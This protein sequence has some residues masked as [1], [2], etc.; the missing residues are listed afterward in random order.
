[1]NTITSNVNSG[2]VSKKGRDNLRT[3]KE[4]HLDMESHH[5]EMIKEKPSKAAVECFKRK[6]YS[7]RGDTNGQR[8]STGIQN[9]ERR[10]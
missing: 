4:R 2:M 6:P 3:G 9:D 7:I 1:M 10:N 5:D 8:N